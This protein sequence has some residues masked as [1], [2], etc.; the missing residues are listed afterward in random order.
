MSGGL[1]SKNAL[2]EATTE[3]KEFE[4]IKSMSKRTMHLI[5]KQAEGTHVY[6]ANTIEMLLNHGCA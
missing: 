3:R 2:T 6:I 5:K 4:A 1:R